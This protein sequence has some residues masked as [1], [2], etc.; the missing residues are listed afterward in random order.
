MK[1]PYKTLKDSLLPA[2]P[3]DK[4]FEDLFS[5][6]QEHSAPG[7]QVIA[8]S[9]NRGHQLE[10]ESGL[11]FSVELLHMALKCV[12]GNFLD[13]TLYAT[14]SQRVSPTWSFKRCC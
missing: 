5:V 6:L 9:F 13:R 11:A 10:G 3:D 1:R 12:L 4:S 7:S 2:Q 14:G 8:N